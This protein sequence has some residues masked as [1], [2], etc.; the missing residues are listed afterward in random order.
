M[1]L[2][3]FKGFPPVGRI[4]G[5]DW[6]LRR[7]GVAVSSPERDFV[8]VRDAIVLPRGAD[9][10]AGVVADLAK[11]ENVVGI[12]VGLPL[13]PDGAESDTTKMVRNFVN[14]LA[15]KTDLPICTLEE[16][17]TSVSAQESMGR[18][19]VRDIK[20][21]LDSESARVILENAIAMINRG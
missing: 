14:G 20:A 8:F 3:D 19:R 6:G 9:N 21:Q 15:T 18:V 2:P 7:I 13:Y 10:H 1:I 4:L 11:Q 16:N 17:L 5:I 12:V